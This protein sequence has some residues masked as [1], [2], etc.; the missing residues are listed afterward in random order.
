M[1]VDVDLELQIDGI[2]EFYSSNPKNNAFYKNMLLQLREDE[3]RIKEL[4]DNIIKEA[5]RATHL[6]VIDLADCSDKLQI[7]YEKRDNFLFSNE[8]T[9]FKDLKK[10]F[11]TRVKNETANFSQQQIIFNS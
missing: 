6:N 1:D 9:Y 11:Q 7:S 5:L 2:A 4:N 10:K 8:N 3:Q